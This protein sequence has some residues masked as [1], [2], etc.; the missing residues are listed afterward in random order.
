MGLIPSIPSLPTNVE[1]IIIVMALAYTG[2]SIAA[3]R[4]LS[5]PKRM[6]EIQSKVQA[7]QK[8]LNSM[9]KSNAPQEELMKK[10][11]EIMPLLGEQ[12]KSSMKPMIV[13]FPLLILTY[14]VVIPHMPLLSKYVSASKSLFFILVFII[15]IITAIVIFI[16]D[17]KM[18]KEERE[19]RK[20]EKIIDQKYSGNNGP[21]NNQ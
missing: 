7:L 12:M 20:D 19:F 8:E 14:Y 5:N 18:L 15:G 13:I 21:Q 2:I 10:Q 6:R 9:M 16:Y 4:L 11:R 17:R 1:I 3:Q